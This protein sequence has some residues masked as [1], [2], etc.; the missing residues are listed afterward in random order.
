LIRGVP[1]SGPSGNA[2]DYRRI[3]IER[4]HRL[5]KMGYD[6]LTPAAYLR[7]EEPAITGILVER[8][9]EVLDGP[10]VEQWFSFFAVHDD[11]PVPDR[12]RRG[13]HRLRLDIKIVSSE[14]RPRA[15]LSFE[16]KRLNES[17]SVGAYL[18]A[19]GLGCFL[20]GR[21]AKGQDDAG[22]LGYVQSDDLSS[23]GVRIGQALAASPER[24]GVLPG[25]SWHTWPMADGPD[26]SYRSRHLR[27][28]LQ[29]EI[30]IYHTLLSFQ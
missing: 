1:V 30:D 5:I 9:D 22:M 21:Y 16:A 4:A 11:P 10:D 28:H 20:E 7:E 14:Q 12:I 29:R 15:V 23:W 18:G 6:C 2:A 13:K 26:H 17:Q 25:H 27:R 19:K 3:F 24:Y 8:I